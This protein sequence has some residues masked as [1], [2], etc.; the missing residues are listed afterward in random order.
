MRLVGFA[1]LG[2]ALHSVAATL[3][4]VSVNGITLRMLLL[5]GPAVVSAVV[6]ALARAALLGIARIVVC[7]MVLP[8]VMAQLAAAS[9]AAQ[10]AAKTSF[11]DWKAQTVVTLLSAFTVACVRRFAPAVVTSRV[12]LALAVVLLVLAVRVR[13]LPTPRSWLGIGASTGIVTATAILDHFFLHLLT[14]KVYTPLLLASLLAVD[15]MPQRWLLSPL[16]VGTKWL[17]LRLLRAF[18]VAVVPFVVVGL[19]ATYAWHALAR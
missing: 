7:N 18:A 16:T 5:L 8:V 10:A 3:S 9:A 11:D 19:S 13:W 17:L 15:V 14:W 4:H 1:A 2:L 12:G 6:A